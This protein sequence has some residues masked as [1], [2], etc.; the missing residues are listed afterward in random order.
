MCGAGPNGPALHT[1]RKGNT[2]MQIRLRNVLAIGALTSGL[3]AGGALVADAA[4]TSSTTGNSGTGNSSSSSSTATTV[5]ELERRE[6][7]VELA[8][9]RVRRARP[10]ARAPARA[11]A[12]RLQLR[13]RLHPQLPEHGQRLGLPHRHASGRLRHPAVRSGSS[14]GVDAP[15]PSR[16]AS[17][18]PTPTEEGRCGPDR[19]RGP[20]RPPLGPPVTRDRTSGSGRRPLGIEG[21]G[22]QLAQRVVDVRPP[23]RR[24]RAA[25]GGRP[26]SRSTPGRDTRRP[27]R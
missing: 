13:L 17:A 8:R 5:V 7:R 2:A 20:H 14:C 19:Q 22:H 27:S 24:A 4:T 6:H 12:R 21:A 3:L 15:A 1:R 25:A 26:A 10:P 16:L 18:S 11:P 9:A 23:P